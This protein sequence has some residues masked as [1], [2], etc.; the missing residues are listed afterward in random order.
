MGGALVFGGFEY[1]DDLLRISKD[2]F[3]KISWFKQKEKV[4][5]SKTSYSTVTV[6]HANIRSNPSLNSE[7]IYNANQLDRLP[8]LQK[9][10]LDNENIMCI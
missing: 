8:Y 7:I 6:E 4:E 9:E 2:Q 1:G 3:S 10:Q 5:V